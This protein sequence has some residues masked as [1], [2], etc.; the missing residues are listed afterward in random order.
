MENEYLE[1][2]FYMERVSGT[3]PPNRDHWGG[4]SPRLR[5]GLIHTHKQVRDAVEA[6]A[7]PVQKQK[8]REGGHGVWYG[9][10][11]ETWVY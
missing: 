9:F 8:I 11:F 1:M 4:R 5:K 6:G 2:S 3:T 7:K 10:I